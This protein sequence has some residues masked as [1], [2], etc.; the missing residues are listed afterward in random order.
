[1]KQNRREALLCA[2]SVKGSMTS[3]VTN[4]TLK[5]ETSIGTGQE[6]GA[7]CMGTC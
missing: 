7:A 2:G 6:T 4:S 1:M 3:G 5:V